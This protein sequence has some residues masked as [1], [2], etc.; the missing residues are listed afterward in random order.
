M[1][2]QFIILLS[3][4]QNAAKNME[5][6]KDLLIK[7]FPEIHFSKSI[8]SETIIHDKEKKF[9]NLPKYYLNSVAIGNTSMRLNEILAFLK[10]SET[11]LGRVRGPLSQ[12][13]VAI[14]LDLIEWNKEVIRPKDASQ[15]YYK[16]CVA[17]IYG[18]HL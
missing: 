15:L 16:D 14:D 1:T 18:K 2:S 10:Q 5:A 6:A 7:N 13:F 12:G 17:D 9:N 11:A 8:E 4:N 3:S